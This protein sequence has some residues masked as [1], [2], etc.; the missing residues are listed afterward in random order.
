MAQWF[1]GKYA[2]QEMY[3]EECRVDMTWCLSLVTSEYK[4]KG[5]GESGCMHMGV[6]YTIL[7]TFV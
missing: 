1:V 3:T 7:F 6:H 4:G 2:H 5:I